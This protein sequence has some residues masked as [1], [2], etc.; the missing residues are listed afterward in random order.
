[1]NRARRTF[2]KTG[3][4]AGAG[5]SLAAFKCVPVYA[6]TKT[7]SGEFDLLGIKGTVQLTL[8]EE[9][10]EGAA[11][12]IRVENLTARAAI[13]QIRFSSGKP[14]SVRKLTITAPVPLR[15]VQKIWH[16]QQLDGMGQH[17]YVGLPWSMEIPASGNCGS[18]IAG[19]TN[20]YG[21]NRGFLGLKNQSGDGSIGFGNGYSNPFLSMSISRFATGRPWR[22]DEIDETVYLSLE[23]THWLNTVQRFVEWYDTALGISHH[24]PQACFDPFWNTWYPSMG[25]LSDD[26]IERN[27]KICADL[28]FKN[29]IIDDGWMKSRFEWEA[30]PEVFPDLRATIDRV[31]AL[32]LRVTLWYFGFCM[33]EHAPDFKKWEKYRVVSNGKPMNIMCA[34]NPEV[35]ERMAEIAGNL[36]RKYN[37]DGLKIDFLD[38]DVGAPLVNCTGDH[39]HDVD[40]VG[41]GV[42]DAARR[43]A[44]AIRAVKPDA[45]IEYRLNYANIANR[46][47][48][49]CYRGQ[50][51]PS[52]PDLARRHLGLI[53]SWCRGVAP[54]S[55]PAYW[56]HDE[57]DEN[58]SRFLASAMLYAVPQ[59]SVNFPEITPNHREL[60]RSW[61]AFY[62]E[63]RER[64]FAGKFEI[65]SDDPHYSVAR[66]SG[67]GRT[68]LPCFLE[69][70]PSSLPLLSGDA[71][72]IILYNGS[73]RARITTR[74]EGAA[75][76][77][78]LSATD[79]FLKPVG[80]TV[81]L[82]SAGGALELDHPVDV[83]GMAWLRKT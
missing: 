16:S 44:E 12:H 58:V 75:G 37:L 61:L 18:F 78:R 52:D 21:R 32:G 25:K 2:I 68:W 41:D 54:H 43:M 3:L 24:T 67:D 72:T 73:G 9:V 66:I 39:H 46:Q 80:K 82:K 29:L 79:K 59:I 28:G 51:T 15:D 17:A 76:T 74:L 77:Y 69:T 22:A 47:W 11:F 35:R 53:R 34:R 71:G 81:A 38:P 45:I 31:H 40:F 48:G 23:D 13:A 5:L 55:D 20:R 14:L 56:A 27:A 63:H 70:W 6:G 1:M 42:Q 4:G 30:K 10:P 83:G 60:V 57:T 64:M 33:D 8:E 7:V 19:A 65:L 50:D 26:F 62:N 49:N 36:M